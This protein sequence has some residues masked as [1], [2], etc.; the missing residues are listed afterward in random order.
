MKNKEQQQNQH[1]GGFTE[2]KSKLRRIRPKQ[3]QSRNEPKQQGNEARTHKLRASNATS[4][5]EQIFDRTQI[6][7]N[8]NN[9]ETGEGENRTK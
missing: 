2:A 5:V 9:P 3:Y 8:S 4:G 7:N 1:R 6:N